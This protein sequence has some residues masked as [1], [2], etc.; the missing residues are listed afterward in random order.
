MPLSAVNLWAVG[1]A[2]VVSMV[3]G[4]AWYSAYLFGK[5]WVKLMGYTSET[6]KKAQREMGPW[7]A[8]AFGLALLQAYVLSMMQYATLSVS[9]SETMMLAF[10]L[11]LGMIVPVQMTGVIFARQPFKLFMINTGYQLTSILVMSMVIGWWR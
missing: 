4:F 8:V 10:W 5:P 6:L 11:W 3:V 9:L 2:G 7:Y 1:L